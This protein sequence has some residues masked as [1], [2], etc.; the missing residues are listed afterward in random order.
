MMMNGRHS[1][2]CR[3]EAQIL[4]EQLFNRRQDR[5]TVLCFGFRGAAWVGLD[6]R[7]QH[8]AR[9]RLLQFAIDTKMVAAEGPCSGD[10]DAQLRTAVYLPAPLP[11]TA[12]RQRP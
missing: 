4:L 2:R 5:N 8:H 3:V 6:G 11:S 1:H 9:P 10:S 7:G 12:L